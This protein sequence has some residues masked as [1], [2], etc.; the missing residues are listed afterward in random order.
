[1]NKYEGLGFF[2]FED[3]VEELNEEE[4][5]AVN[6]GACSGGGASTSSSPSSVPHYSGSCSGGGASTPSSTPSVP[7]YSGGCSGGGAVTTSRPYNPTPSCGGGYGYTQGSF[8][9]IYNSAAKNAKMQDY[10]NT[11]NDSK[12]NGEGNLFSKVGCKMMGFAKILSQATGKFFS[13]MDINNNYDQGKDGL[14]GRDE[15]GDALKKNLKNKKVTVDYWEKGLTKE[16]LDKITRESGTT[17]I[18][19]KAK[20]VAGGDH[21][22][23]LEG[24]TTNSYGQVE[25]SY[26]GTSK[27]DVGR[28]FIL[29]EPTATQKKNNYYQITKIETFNVR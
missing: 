3:F 27:N 22:I 21:W 11:T 20:D 24:Y 2:D 10:A 29:G 8:G 16:R 23:V 7:H 19:G 13:L 17:Y 18:L 14:I 5:F 25:F 26:N 15:I 1:M 9:Y 4:L 6:G 28:K 12:M